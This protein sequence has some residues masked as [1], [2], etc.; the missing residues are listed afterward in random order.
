MPQ[1]VRVWSPSPTEESACSSA[2]LF[3]VSPSPAKESTG[4][5]T[6]LVSESPSPAKESTCCCAT[7]LLPA[8]TGSL[9]R[10]GIGGGWAR[11]CRPI[12]ALAAKDV[13]GRKIVV[14]NMLETRVLDTMPAQQ[15]GPQHKKPFRNRPYRLCTLCRCPQKDQKNRKSPWAGSKKSPK[16]C[17]A[18]TRYWSRLEN[19]KNTGRSCREERRGKR[20]ARRGWPGSPPPST[21]SDL[22]VFSW[23]S[24]IPLLALL[25]T[26]WLSLTMAGAVMVSSH[27]LV[28]YL[29]DRVVEHAHDPDAEQ[30]ARPHGEDGI[31]Q[32]PQSTVVSPFRTCWCRL[33]SA[34]RRSLGSW[35]SVPDHQEIIDN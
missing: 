4:S 30:E 20:P 11:L 29:P 6:S 8:P 32:S 3:S 14:R 25:A 12:T 2:F 1:Q 15:Q 22:T 7:S 24:S 27:S 17:P 35:V 18:S 19:A 26:L 5:S 33:R 21:W 23:I 16:G 34:S 9:S 28:F 10:H 13:E 31:D